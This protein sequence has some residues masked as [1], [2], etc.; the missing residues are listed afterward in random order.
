MTANDR[1]SSTPPVDPRS[2][3]SWP[4]ALRLVTKLMT[5][6]EGAAAQ[7]RRMIQQQHKHEREWHRSRQ[8]LVETQQNR[9][10]AEDKVADVL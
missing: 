3:V 1:P 4:P 8:A 7:V 5:Q 9:K 6:N 2:I 10:A